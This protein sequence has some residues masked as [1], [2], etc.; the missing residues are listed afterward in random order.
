L[1][2]RNT[3]NGK[4]HFSARIKGFRADH[5]ILPVSAC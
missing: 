3:C 1:P 2:K 4:R 5:E